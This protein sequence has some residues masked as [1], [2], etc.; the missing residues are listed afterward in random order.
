MRRQVPNI[1][2]CLVFGNLS[3]ALGYNLGRSSS[4]IDTW[5]MTCKDCISFKARPVFST[6]LFL[7]FWTG[8]ALE[9]NLVTNRPAFKGKKKCRL[10]RGGTW[11]LSSAANSQ[12]VKEK[13]LAAVRK[14]TSS[15]EKVRQAVSVHIFLG[16]PPVVYTF[17]L[18]RLVS[19][20][21]SLGIH[22]WSG[23]FCKRD[24]WIDP[25][26]KIRAYSLI[27]LKGS[28]RPYHSFSFAICFTRLGP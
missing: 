21:I 3:T 4:S 2:S 25:E 26:S 19:D 11:F 14:E 13:I 23:I 16:T 20:I 9:G 27:F 5:R 1:Q 15:W 18:P 22:H 12:M 28:Y 6:P 17:S 24:Q 10:V 7:I 8:R